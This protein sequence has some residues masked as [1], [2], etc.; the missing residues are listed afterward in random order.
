M[1]HKI[2]AAC[3]L[4]LGCAGVGS[5]QSTAPSPETGAHCTQA[6]VKQLERN[7]HAPDQ[8]K[9]LASYYGERQKAYL[10][11]AAE[12]KKEWER[13]S[14]NVS[15]AFAKYPRPADSSRNLYEYYMSKAS[16]AGELE[17]KYS[18]LTSP[19]APVNAQ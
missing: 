9:V 11:Q 8:Y 18:R 7:A 5:A 2:L 16:K 1:T 19:D 4:T 10:Q 17:A 12:E 6:Q 13:R 3:I 14:K 15:G